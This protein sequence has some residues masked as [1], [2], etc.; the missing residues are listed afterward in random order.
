MTDEPKVIRVSGSGRLLSY[1]DL[2]RAIQALDHPQ[3]KEHTMAFG[4]LRSRASCG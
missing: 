2:Y 1:D 4:R 3:Q